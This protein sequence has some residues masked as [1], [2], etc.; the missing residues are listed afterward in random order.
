L[1]KEETQLRVAVVVDRRQ[2]NRYRRKHRQHY[3]YQAERL[4]SDILGLPNQF[5]KVK[6]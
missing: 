1:E 6:K 4:Q 3:H 5:R 2:E